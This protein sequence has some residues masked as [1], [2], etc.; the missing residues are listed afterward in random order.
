MFRI[1][2]EQRVFRMTAYPPHNHQEC[3]WDIVSWRRNHD[4]CENCGVLFVNMDPMTDMIQ[5]WTGACAWHKG[6][7]DAVPA[8]AASMAVVQL[9]QDVAGVVPPTTK[10][11]NEL[12]LA[13]RLLRD[14]PCLLGSRP[15]D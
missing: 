5:H 1:E 8:I 15:E 9:L 7:A 14:F 4:L 10:E 6:D 11:A 13:I 3:T 2:L 12:R